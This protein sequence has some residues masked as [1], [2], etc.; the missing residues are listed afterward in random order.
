MCVYHEISEWPLIRRSS[1]VP[2]NYRLLEVA[3]ATSFSECQWTVGGL[4]TPDFENYT[5]TGF[6][7]CPLD[8][9]KFYNFTDGVTRRVDLCSSLTRCIGLVSPKRSRKCLHL[10]ANVYLW[11]NLKTKQIMPPLKTPY[12]FPMETYL[13]YVEDCI[14][15]AFQEMNQHIVLLTVSISMFI[16][17]VVMLFILAKITSGHRNTRFLINPTLLD[18]DVVTSNVYLPTTKKIYKKLSM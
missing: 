4:R 3:N 13:K 8:N 1:N 14:K 9:L 5:V 7:N 6:Y 15:A 16:F 2:V 10:L 11:R 17:V 18:P 12:Q